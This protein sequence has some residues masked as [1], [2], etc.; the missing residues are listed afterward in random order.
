[1]SQFPGLNFSS[2]AEKKEKSLLHLLFI[3]I[4]EKFRHSF[5]LE[6]RLLMDIL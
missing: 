3:L 2:K 6:V 4:R 5:C 1:M